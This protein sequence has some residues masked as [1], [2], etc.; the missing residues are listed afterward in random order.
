MDEKFM[1]EILDDFTPAFAQLAGTE[2]YAITLSGSYGKG[3]ADK[4]SDFDFRIYYEKSAPREVRREAYAKI[5]S[6]IEKWEKRN[7]VVEGIWPRTYAEVDGANLKHT[8]QFIYKPKDFEEKVE[9]I[10]YV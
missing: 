5:N 3:F 4:N 9:D 7:I 2:N 8:E 1:R 10:L 6:L